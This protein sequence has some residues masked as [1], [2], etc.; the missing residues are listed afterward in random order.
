MSRRRQFKQLLKKVRS[1]ETGTHRFCY[2]A[3]TLEKAGSYYFY[4]RIAYKTNQN[5]CLSKAW[6]ILGVIRKRYLLRI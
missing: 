1:K 6:G 4:K 5:K 2:A 3:S